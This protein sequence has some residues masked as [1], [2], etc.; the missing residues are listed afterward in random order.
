M[1]RYCSSIATQDIL[2]ALGKKDSPG[3]QLANL[4]SRYLVQRTVQKYI[5]KKQMQT[6]YEAW[7]GENLSE[8]SSSPKWWGYFLCG[9]R[10][11]Q[12]EVMTMMIVMMMMMIKMIM[13]I[14]DSNMFLIMMMKM[15]MMITGW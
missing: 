10:G 8:L 4:D 14:K 11:V 6:R 15:T 2:A 7:E 13:L 9:V 12:E 5:Y 1:K 3:L